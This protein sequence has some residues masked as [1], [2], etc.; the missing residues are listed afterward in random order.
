MR[1]QLGQHQWRPQ[2]SHKL[3]KLSCG[4]INPYTLTA[5]LGVA[6]TRGPD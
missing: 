5:R 1:A 2:R 3:G 4:G 6:Q